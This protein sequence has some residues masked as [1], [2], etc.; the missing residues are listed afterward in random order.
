MLNKKFQKTFNPFGVDVGKIRE[1]EQDLKAWQALG[2]KQIAPKKSATDL[3]K[4]YQKNIERATVLALSLTVLGFAGLRSTGFATKQLDKPV[5]EFM[6][7]SIPPTEQFKRPPAPERPSVAIPS[8]DL[9][10][11]EE[12]TI[13]AT[14]IDFAQVPAPPPPPEATD[15]SSDIFIEYDSP[16]EPVGGYGEIYRNLVYPKLARKAGMEGLVLVQVLV[17]ASGDVEK[18]TVLKDSGSKVGFEEAAVEAVRDV[19]WKPALQRDRPVRV[20][21]TIPIRFQLTANLNS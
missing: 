9:S 14:T 6:V 5:F 1:T 7:E 15:E 11:P 8:D 16:P 10:L 18:V 21:V 3:K 13:A 12:E 4:T 19:Q 17:N 20:A 2:A